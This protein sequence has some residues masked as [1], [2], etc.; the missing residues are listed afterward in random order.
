MSQNIL[1]HRY[2]PSDI[3]AIWAAVEESRAEL[4]RWM[5]WCHDDYSREDARIWVEGRA[6]AWDANEEWGFIIVDENDRL[7]GTCGIHR[8]DL[9]HRVGELGYWVRTSAAGRGVA[10]QATRQL[11]E[12][13]FEE[14]CLRRIEILTDVENL[15]S[16][17][18]AIKVGGIY[19]G[20]LRNRLLVEGRSH[21]CML[22]AVLSDNL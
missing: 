15:A 22:F 13:A 1:L 11:C 18:V 2:Q 10:T 4:T 14:K 9:M 20:T 21:D 19:E 17:R 6:A 3:D 16:Q 5:A 12:W 8:I 7:L